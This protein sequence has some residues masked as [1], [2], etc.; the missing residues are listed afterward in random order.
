VG[1]AIA[2]HGEMSEELEEQLK[3]ALEEFAK[4]FTV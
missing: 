1:A 2:E 4:Q 3:S